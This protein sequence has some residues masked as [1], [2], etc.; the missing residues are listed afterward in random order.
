LQLINFL[1][2]TLL[3]SNK[4][5]SVEKVQKVSRV[6]DLMAFVKIRLTFTVVLSAALGFGIAPTPFDL[7]NLVLLVFGGFMITGAANGFNQIIERDIDGLMKRTKTRPL[8]TGRMKVP[9]AFII[10]SSMAIAGI[11]FLYL[12]NPLSAILGF[13]AFFIYVAL[14]TPLKKVSS[15]AVFV[16]AI[17]GAIPPMLGYVAAN[18]HFGLEPGILFAVQ[19]IWQ[20]P[21]FWAI[22]WVSD[23]EYKK[24]GY[25]LLPSKGGKDSF[26]AFQMFLYSL[27]LIPV[28]LLPWAYGMTGIWSAIVIAILG[29]AFASLAWKHSR[30]LSDKTA[31]RIMFASF[32]YLPIV[33]LLYLLNTI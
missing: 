18:G 9:E 19:F 16:G 15:F 26:S 27:F 10:A 25:H 33:Q 29:L 31:L 4:T 22:A 12:I 30:V 24:A 17:P 28:S 6:R 11:V 2:I 21:H 13:L 14:Y 7:W 23:E 32:I 20:F 1:I 5:I 3:D 8:P